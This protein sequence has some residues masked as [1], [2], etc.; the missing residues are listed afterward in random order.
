MQ[1][2]WQEHAGVAAPDSLTQ[3]VKLWSDN[4]TC[5]LVEPQAAAKKHAA[6]YW[7]AWWARFQS[8]SYGQKNAVYRKVRDYLHLCEGTRGQSA[9]SAR[10]VLRCGRFP[11]S[12][13]RS[14]PAG[15]AAAGGLASPPVTKAPPVVPAPGVWAWERCC[16][17]EL[18][19][20][21]VADLERGE[22]RE[23]QGSKGQGS[24]G[25]D[26]QEARQ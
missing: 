3:T 17:V 4:L 11:G 15:I 24:K 1:R 9:W 22:D 2:L 25:Q 5:M 6:S 23:G 12:R 18:G 7:K 13:Q 8:M 20:D 10:G 21:V 16:H 26:R 14:R 19:A